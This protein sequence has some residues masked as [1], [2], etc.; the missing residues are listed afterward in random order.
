MMKKVVLLTTGGTIASK[1]NKT[2]GK[3]ASGA[4]TGEE[5][6]A[7]CHLPNEIEVIVESVFQKA[8]IHITFDDLVFLKTKNYPLKKQKSNQKFL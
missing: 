5:L 3:L 6:A 4:I 8:S 1:P 7:M 2:S